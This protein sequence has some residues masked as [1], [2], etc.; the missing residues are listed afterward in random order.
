MTA[1]K[2]PAGIDRVM[3]KM[4]DAMASSKVAGRRSITSERADLFL[5]IESPQSPLRMSAQKEPNCTIR[6]RS[7][8][9]SWRILSSCP[10]KTR[11]PS[12]IPTT[13]PERWVVKKTTEDITARTRMARGIRLRRNMPI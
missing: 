11:S 3:D 12:I 10:G 4:K 6:G 1:A 8:P 5:Q 2:I 7:S 9:S 13:S